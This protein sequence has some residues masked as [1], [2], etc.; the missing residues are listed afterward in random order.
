MIYKI[1]YDLQENIFHA[2]RH[3]NHRSLKI[4]GLITIAASYQ[5]TRIGANKT[6][7]NNSAPGKKP[8][9]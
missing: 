5:V 4:L 1:Y 3:V 9:S 6:L 8:T 2:Y 7:A